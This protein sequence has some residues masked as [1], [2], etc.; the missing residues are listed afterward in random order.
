LRVPVI[1]PWAASMK[2]AEML[3]GLGLTHGKLAYMTPPAK[4]MRLS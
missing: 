3:V 2:F 4:A 1:D